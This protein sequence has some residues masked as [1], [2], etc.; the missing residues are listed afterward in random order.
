MIYFD[1]AATTTVDDRVI[2]EIFKGMLVYGN[3]SSSYS[4]GKEAKKQIKASRN[5]IE[6][7]LGLPSDSFIF[8]SGGSESDN[9]AI[10]SV[11]ASG[12]KT[13][14][15]IVVSEIEHHAVLNACRALVEQGAIIEYA[16]VHPDGTLDLNDLRQKVDQNTAIVSVMLSNNEIG[17]TLNIEAAAAIAHSNGALFHTDAVQGVTHYPAFYKPY[18]DMFSVS[19]HKFGAPKGIGGLFVRPELM[20]DM[21]GYELISGG[22]QEHGLRGGTENV[23][24]IMGLAKAVE[25]LIEE[26]DLH[27]KKVGELHDYAVTKIAQ[28]FQYATFNGIASIN[29]K[30]PS[31]LNVCLHKADGSAVVEWMDL[32]DI[33]ISSGSACNTGSP[34]PSHVLMAIGL[35]ERDAFSSIRLSFSSKNTKAEIDRFIAVLKA[36]ECR[37]IH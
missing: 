27:N 10:R 36:F 24:Y 6:Q 15:K 33:C 2:N 25:N 5:K 8:T 12:K 37:H 3:P 11:F 21:I 32:H 35:S 34:H 4:I 29:D 31:I 14:N 26:N 17:T 13:K 22:K 28:N 16:K 19:G 9:F 1:H 7:L 18:I 23:P 20:H 30:N